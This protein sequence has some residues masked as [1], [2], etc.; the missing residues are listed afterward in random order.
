MLELNNTENTTSTDILVAAN[1]LKEVN[2]APFELIE[3]VVNQLQIRL[4][5]SNSSVVLE[6][7]KALLDLIS[8][9]TDLIGN[10]AQSLYNHTQ[11]WTRLAAI[12]L[13]L[14]CGENYVD[15]NILKEAIDECIAEPAKIY[16][17]FIIQQKLKNYGKYGREFQNQVLLQGS[18]LLLK[19]YPTLETAK[20]IKEVISSKQ[21]SSGIIGELE[22][23]LEK[24]IFEQIKN[25]EN[26]DYRKEWTILLRELRKD[27][28]FMNPQQLLMIARHRER[29]KYADKSFLEAVLRVTDNQSNLSLSLQQKQELISLGVLFKGMGWW[30][31]PIPD[32]DILS[33]NKDLEAVDAVI[34][35][36][37]VSLNIEH[38][39]IAMEAKI[40]LEQI[41][42]YEDLDIIESA[43]EG[44]KIKSEHSS[45][46][47]D[48]A[49]DKMEEISNQNYISLFSKIPQVPADTE[50]ERAREIDIS[51][52]H[53]VRAL[54]HPSQ[55]IY[56][57]AT[58]LLMNGVGGSEAINLIEEL[59][60]EN[61]DN[62]Q[63][64]WAVSNIAPHLLEDE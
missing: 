25:D 28:A 60:K 35:G 14:Q 37:I 36:T 13:G 64:V 27:K 55:V 6:A 5:S 38:Q 23:T 15:L 47:F 48:W 34:K 49:W 58:L 40:V 31:F 59:F 17:P 30:N 16:S 24:H 51:P 62:E 41:Q 2:N 9:A 50:W 19:K 32:W 61:K 1:A 12:R 43:L 63:V 39:K 57:N 54:K 33:E 18:Q 4:E 46:T 3:A 26:K 21:L 22:K 29:Q 20:Y 52:E 45:Q 44:K 11:S 42:F 53:L 8:Q 10:I 56:Q 7:A